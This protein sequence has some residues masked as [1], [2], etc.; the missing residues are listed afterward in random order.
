MMT[1]NDFFKITSVHR[2]D[3]ASIL[4]DK[5]YTLTDDEM[6]WLARKMADDYIE[7][8]FWTQIEYLGG[9]IFE[10]RDSEND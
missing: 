6:G 3:V 2:D 1:D 5:A 10:K 7:Q 9:R 4:G 8:L